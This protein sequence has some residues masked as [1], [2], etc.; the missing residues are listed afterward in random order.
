MIGYEIGIYL[1]NFNII[2]FLK[3]GETS[4]KIFAF[5]GIDSSYNF[6]GGC[7]R[8]SGIDGILL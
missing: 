7:K 1:A 6:Y 2:K 5:L 3:G 8:S 4:D